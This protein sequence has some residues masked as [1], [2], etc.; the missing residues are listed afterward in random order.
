MNLKAVV[1]YILASLLCLASA[2]LNASPI[3]PDS[4][5]PVFE[6]SAQTP[7]RIDVESHMGLL[8]DS[9]R[10]LAP[11]QVMAPAKVW[12]TITR[13][14][15]NFGFTNDAYWFRFQIDNLGQQDAARFIEL[16]IPFIDDV[17]LYHYTAG[18][19]KTSYRLGDEMPFAQRVVRH[20]NFVMPLNLAPGANLI[21][22]R[23]ASSGTIEAPFRIWDPTRF[24]EANDD[25]KLLQG[26]VIGI[27]LIMIFYNLFVYF[28][29]RDVNY[30]YYIGFVASYLF[31]HVSLNGY[32]FAYVWPAAVRW[33]SIAISTFVASSE[34]FASL[35]A[36]SF[37]RLSA[38]SRPAHY[39]TRA[40]VIASALLVALTFVLPYSWTVRVGAAFTIP[41]C[42]TALALGYWRWWRGAKFARYYCIAWTTVLISLSVL[43]AGK[44][45]LVPSNI[46]T[47]NASQIGIVLLVL[48][49]SFTLTD[50]INHDR[51]LRINAQAVALG[52]ER[53]ARSAQ[54]ALL[55]TKE[56]ANRELE[57]RVTARTND[58]NLTLDQLQLANDQLQRLSSVDGLTQISNRAFFDSA[59]AAEH[60]R[61]DRAKSSLSVVMIDLDHFK[62][63]ND[64]YGHL[65][66]D[67][68][69][70]A[71]AGLMRPRIQRVGDVLARYGGEEFVMLLIDSSMKDSMALAEGF[72]ADIEK[73]AIPFEGRTIRVT[74]SFGVASGI[75]NQYLSPQALLA[76]A[77]KALYQAKHDGRNC[78][79]SWPTANRES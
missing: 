7:G 66:G 62:L 54:E 30:L 1:L 13:R 48:F 23:L 73:L 79:R 31:F 28:S 55:K 27:L 41:I 3:A 29:T 19:L 35:F 4:S 40:L 2:A 58:L 20:Q 37:L 74:A 75:P 32:A 72:R 34:L 65:G 25:D 76:Q 45:G 70:R 50:R 57:Q 53:W 36:G 24:Y 46:W 47:E 15:P 44:F 11:D 22:I 49:L 8:V 61:A 56:E 67:A 5:F 12:Q 33:N 39:L 59:L 21:Y 42:L 71:L 6:V 51:T 64:T 18:Q 52:H 10:A 16:P 68:C 63:V 60:R 26:L 9:T 78:V 77:D 69:L 14:S 43:N 38:F 17:Q